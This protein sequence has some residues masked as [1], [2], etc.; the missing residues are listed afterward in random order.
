MAASRYG[1][2]LLARVDQPKAAPTGEH[3]ARVVKHCNAPA[4]PFPIGGISHTI[5][6]GPLTAEVAFCPVDGDSLTKIFPLR[7]AVRENTGE[8]HDAGRLGLDDDSL[9]IPLEN[10]TRSRSQ[11]VLPLQLSNIN[12]IEVLASV[13]FGLCD[14][15]RFAKR[16]NDRAAIVARLPKAIRPKYNFGL[17]LLASPHALFFRPPTNVTPSASAF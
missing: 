6:P 8:Q 13:V 9:I 1:N 16:K 12:S 5:E 4:T 7:G 3:V 11:Q 10:G 15:A 17:A 2:L 14:F